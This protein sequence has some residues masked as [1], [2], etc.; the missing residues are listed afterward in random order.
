MSLLHQHQQQQMLHPVSTNQHDGAFCNGYNLTVYQSSIRSQ[1]IHIYHQHGS[2]FEIPQ[3]NTSIS[4][5]AIQHNSVRCYDALDASTEA[6]FSKVKT[7][8]LE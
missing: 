1:P 2:K 3:H 4:L 6:F 5:A 7:P 8:V